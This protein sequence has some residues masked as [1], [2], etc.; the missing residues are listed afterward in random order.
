[1]SGIIF[2]YDECKSASNKDKHGID[3]VEAQLLWKDKNL[4]VAPLQYLDEPRFLAVGKI[5]SKHYSA[6]FTYRNENL[7]LISVR[8]ARKEEV[9][10]Y[11]K[12]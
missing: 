8:R 7:R 10:A 5:K 2:E 12:H 4:I 3:F 6:I 1:M 11:E 9:T